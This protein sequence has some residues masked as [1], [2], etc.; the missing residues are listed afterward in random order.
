MRIRK[1]ILATLFLATLVLGV[2]G[3]TSAL[4]IKAGWETKAVPSGSAAILY[5]ATESYGLP[6]AYT[7]YTKDG[8]PF[9]ITRAF[10]GTGESVSIYVPA[11][12]PIT[13]PGPPPVYNSGTFSALMTV[14]AHT[15]TV[16]VLPWSE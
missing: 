7:L 1:S 12:K 10:S 8:S 3:I 14:K 15:D 11:G 13:V 2:A 4:D 6:K 9:Y 5:Q 16:F